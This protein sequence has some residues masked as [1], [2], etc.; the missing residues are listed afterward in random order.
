VLLVDSI[1]DNRAYVS[2]EPDVRRQSRPA[3]ALA[4]AHKLS[5]CCPVS[6]L[7]HSHRPSASAL[8]ASGCANPAPPR[9]REGCWNKRDCG[10]CHY[11]RAARTCAI[12]P[13]GPTLAASHPGQSLHRMRHIHDPAP[14][15]PGARAAGPPRK[16]A[17]SSTSRHRSRIASGSAAD[18]ARRTAR[19]DRVRAGR[20]DPAHRHPRHAC[21]PEL[22]HAKFRLQARQEHVFLVADIFAKQPHDP[23]Q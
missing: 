21:R 13:R 7:H 10:H 14:S 23:A 9:E 19:N 11:L 17:R 16:A 18:V 20:Y 3:G 12:C 4:G 2:P 1:F 6:P 15:L 22:T 8:G 5:R